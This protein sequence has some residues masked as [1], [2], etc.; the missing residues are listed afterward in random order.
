MCTPRTHICIPIGSRPGLWGCPWAGEMAQWIKSLPHSSENSFGISRV[1]MKARWPWKVTYNLKSWG[2]R[3]NIPLSKLQA[4]SS[5][6]GPAAAKYKAIKE[7]LY[8]H[9]CSHTNMCAHIPYT[10]TILQNR[11][12]SLLFSIAEELCWNEIKTD[13]SVLQCPN[14]M[15][16]EEGPLGWQTKSY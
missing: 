13:Q 1:L 8:V 7:S 9:T 6:R 15:A 10:H 4:P 16:A 14:T 3:R 12:G 5:A 2:Q 11:K